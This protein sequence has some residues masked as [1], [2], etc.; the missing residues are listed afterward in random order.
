MDTL[1]SRK[2]FL[3]PFLR[4]GAPPPPVCL[5]SCKG[6]WWSATLCLQVWTVQTICH[7]LCMRV[8]NRSVVSDSAIPWTVA[9]Q[10]LLSMEFSRQEVGSHSLLQGIFSTQRSNLGL[11]HCTRFF[12]VWATG[13]HNSFNVCVCVLLLQS[14]PTLY[15]S[16]TVAC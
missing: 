8:L 6:S 11:L 1:L 10:A 7:L 4:G 3:V 15:N 16:W 13:M 2:P 14:C 5:H 9:H 12:T